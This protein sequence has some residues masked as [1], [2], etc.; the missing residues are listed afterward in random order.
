MIVSIRALYL[1]HRSIPNV[2]MLRVLRATDSCNDLYFSL[3]ANSG[4][5][6]KVVKSLGICCEPPDY[7]ISYMLISVVYISGEYENGTEV[8]IYKP[9]FDSGYLPIGTFPYNDFHRL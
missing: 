9:C 4:I 3:R 2:V 5:M 1:Q 6:Y 7:N 8:C